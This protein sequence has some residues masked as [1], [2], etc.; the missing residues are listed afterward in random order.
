MI[1]ERSFEHRF[2]HTDEQAVQLA[3]TFGYARLFTIRSLNFAPMRLS[4]QSSLSSEQ[5]NICSSEG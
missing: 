5:A 1:V 3:R 4:I 2:F